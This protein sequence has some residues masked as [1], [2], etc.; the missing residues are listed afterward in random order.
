M[1]TDLPVVVSFSPFA[2]RF[3]L[4]D[5]LVKLEVVWGATEVL[6]VVVTVLGV[7]DKVWVVDEICVVDEAGVV[8]EEGAA[9]VVLILLQRNS[10]TVPNLFGQQEIGNSSF[11]VICVQSSGL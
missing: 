7:V 9:E 3:L 1:E 10:P 11:F 5:L 8:G 6:E 4:L 2:N